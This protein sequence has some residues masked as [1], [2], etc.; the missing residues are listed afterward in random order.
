MRIAVIIENIAA[1]VKRAPAVIVVRLPGEKEK[2]SS[3]RS[4]AASQGGGESGGGQ[5]AF[6]GDEI[7]HG[8]DPCAGAGRVEAICCYTHKLRQA[9]L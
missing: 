6:L 7:E 8:V 4:G 3:R 2:R 1:A 5:M 9:A